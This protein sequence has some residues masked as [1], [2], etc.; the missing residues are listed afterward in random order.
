[1]DEIVK[2]ALKKWPNVPACYGWLGLDARGDWYLRDEATQ[3]A[4]PFPQSKGSRIVHD[5]LKDFIQRNYDHDAN[6]AWFFQN[7]P[8][9]VY[10]QLECAPL[11]L[12]VQRDSTGA[13]DVTTHAGQRVAQVRSSWL[14][15][16]GRLYLDTDLG[17]GLLRSLDMDVAADALESGAWGEPTEV[18]F[19]ALPEQFGFCL[20]PQP[21]SSQP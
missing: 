11:I 1:M 21:S 8:Q 17:L 19:E 15:E 3:A 13:F 20:N 9:R 10:V 7:G 12:G 6:G 4:G 16:A 18:V 2:A 5:K 14:D